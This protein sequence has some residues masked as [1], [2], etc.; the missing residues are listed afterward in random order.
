MKQVL[1]TDEQIRNLLLCLDLVL[2]TEGLT[3]LAQVVE[4]HNVL[5]S[6]QPLVEEKAVDEKEEPEGA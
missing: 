4:L 2:K 3:S 5:L 1:L 6:A